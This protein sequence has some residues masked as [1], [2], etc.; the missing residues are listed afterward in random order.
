MKTCLICHSLVCNNAR[1]LITVRLF[2][3]MNILCLFIELAQEE[4]GGSSIDVFNP[5]R[6]SEVG[7]KTVLY[8][9]LSLSQ[10]RFICNHNA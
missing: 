4:A 9:V 6:H 3:K 1:L 5:F 7:E 2:I 10:P 8:A